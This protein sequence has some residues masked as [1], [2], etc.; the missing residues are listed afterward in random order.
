MIKRNKTRGDTPSEHI[1]H[2]RRRFTVRN[3]KHLIAMKHLRDLFL[4]L[5]ILKYDQTLNKFGNNCTICLEQ[6]K[7]KVSVVKGICSH[8]FHE[9]SL[10]ELLYKDINK[11][12]HKCPN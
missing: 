6:F 3:V 5:N 12:E 4:K 7:Y 1:H 2:R 8:I 11:D 9:K 10:K